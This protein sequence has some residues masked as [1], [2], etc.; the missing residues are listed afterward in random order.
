MEQNRLS[1]QQMLSINSC[2]CP[3]KI[4]LN[5]NWNQFYYSTSAKPHTMESRLNGIKIWSDVKFSVFLGIFSTFAHAKCLNN[6]K[7]STTALDTHTKK[8]FN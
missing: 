6:E 7:S 1:I 8:W 2:L 5:Y 4:V 3:S